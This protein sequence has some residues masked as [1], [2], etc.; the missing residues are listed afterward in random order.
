MP[1]A[2]TSTG[3]IEKVLLRE[4]ANGLAYGLAENWGRP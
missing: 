3:N 4:R 2:K 1:W